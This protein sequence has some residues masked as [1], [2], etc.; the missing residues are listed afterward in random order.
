M[1]RIAAAVT[2]SLLAATAPAVAVSAAAAPIAAAPVAAMPASVPGELVVG[3]DAGVG[4]AASTAV[5]ARTGSRLVERLVAPKAGRRAVE[6]VRIPAGQSQAE[7]IAVLEAQPGVAYAEPNWILTKSDVSNDP[8]YTAGQLWGMGGNLT[9]PASTYGSQA[10]EAWAA[11]ATGSSSV[12]VGV[13]DEGIDVS[14]PDLAAN[15]WQNPY[16]PVNGI[17]DDGNGYIDD[18]NGWDFVNNDRGVYDAGVDNHGTHVSGTIGGVGGNGIGVAGVNW[19]VTLISGKFLGSGGGSIANAV[20]AIDYMTDLKVRHGLDIVATSNSWGGGGYSL[21]MQDAINRAAKA[22]ILFIAAAGNSGTNNDTTAAYPANYSS[23]TNG[24]AVSAATYDNVVSVAAI[25]SAGALASWSQYGATTVDLGAPGVSVLSTLPGSTYGVYSGTSMATPH[26]SGAAALIA[27]TWGLRGAALETALLNAVTPTTSLAG[28]TATGGRLDLSRVAP[29]PD[30][31]APTVAI[32]SPANGATITT[33][34]TVTVAAP[35]SDDRG[36]VSVAL[37]ATPPGGSATKLATDTAA[38]FSFAWTPA[39]AGTWA[40][41]TVATDVSG[42]ATTSAPVSVTV[43][44]PVVATGLRV[45]SLTTVV[46]GTSLVV[47]ATITTN[48]GTPAKSANVAVSL[49]KSGAT[50]V[51]KSFTGTTSSA[52]VISWKVSSIPTGCYSSKV[53]SVKSGSLVWDKVSPPSVTNP[54]R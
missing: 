38:P 1:R 25:D 50:K 30:V 42:L 31:T 23:L 32:S 14:H 49:Y 4:T 54:C 5:R 3:Y 46:S 53:T 28:K 21:A 15:V 9:T 17:D 35:A 10:A 52:G 20:K 51:Y 24:S 43:S 47:T 27:A 33:G 37:W 11:G 13:I 7:A 6:R 19:N 29:G 8:S 18:T 44:A 36:V 12:Y 26:V 45:S 34:T 41:S 40:L 22:D 39:T 2:V 16:D 48:L